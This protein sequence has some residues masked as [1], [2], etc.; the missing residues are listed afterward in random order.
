MIETIRA[1]GLYMRAR[2]VFG[3]AAIVALSAF[4]AIGALSPRPALAEASLLERIQERA[5]LRGEILELLKSNDPEMVLAAFEEAVA[6]EDP[7][8]RLSAFEVAF[9]S[10]DPRLRKAALRHFLDGRA[11]LRMEVVLPDRPDKAQQLLFDSYHGY[12][13]ETLKIDPKSDILTFDQ[14]ANKDWSGQLVE[15]GFDLTLST[16]TSTYGWLNC[17]MNMRIADPKQL[18]GQ[19]D[20]TI[21]GQELMQKTGDI[22]RGVV[23]VVIRM[24]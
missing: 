3:C 8:L 18:T 20:C 10:K 21:T 1:K 22:T 16:R 6:G 23:S 14:R 5:K 15:D 11:E 9:S 24:S 13:F 7:E 19:F 4:V 2:Q 12:R 17:V